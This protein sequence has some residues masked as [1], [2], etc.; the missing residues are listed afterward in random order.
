MFTTNCSLDLKTW[1]E[2][3]F[4][5]SFDSDGKE[6]ACNAGDLGS[7]PELEDLL[8]KGMAAHSNILA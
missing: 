7:I 3:D 2:S 8:E 5:Y 6:T 4:I 1:S